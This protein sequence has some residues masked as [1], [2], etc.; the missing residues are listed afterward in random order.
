LKASES[1]EDRFWEPIIR[2]HGHR[3]LMTIVA[4]GIPYDR[5][6]D[7]AQLTWAR[8]VQQHRE[9]RLQDPRF[10]GVALA[11]ARFIAL[12]ELRKSGAESRA[13]AR[14]G[15]LRDT[16]VEG[17]P[18]QEKRMMSRQALERAHGVIMR[19]SMSARRVFEL[20]YVSPGRPHAEIAEEV[21]LSVQRVRQIICEIRRE[22]RR[23]LE[24]E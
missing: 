11:Q 21:G 8:L 1:A 4:F 22:L 23:A 19:S 12:D 10:P 24:E 2:D 9:G 17:P 13:L 6:H 7:L 3:V 20:V 5:A 14:F 15:E 18:D 16:V